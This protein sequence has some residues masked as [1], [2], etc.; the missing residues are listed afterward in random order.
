MTNMWDADGMGTDAEAARKAFEASP[1]WPYV[2]AFARL[3]EAK[4]AKNRHKG[5]RSGWIKNEP[6]RLAERLLEELE[7]LETEIGNG[8]NYVPSRVASEAADVANF[9]MMIADVCGGLDVEGETK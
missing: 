8:M 2:L 5:D 1:T 3:M 7:E 9:A 6:D 4:L